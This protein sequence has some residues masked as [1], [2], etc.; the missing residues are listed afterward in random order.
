LLKLKAVCFRSLHKEGAYLFIG[1]YGGGYYVMKSKKLRAMPLDINQHLKYAH[2][3]MMDDAGYCWI[4]TNSGLFKARLSDITTAFDKDQQHIYY[5]YLGKDD[6]MEITE[7][8]G[9][10]TP[11]AIRLKNRNFSFPTMDGLVWFNPEKMNIAL[12]GGEIYLDKLIVDDK[13]IHETGRAV[14]QLPAQVSRIEATFVTSA[15]C[16]KENLH[17]TYQLDKGP[18]LPVDMT[19]GEPR[20]SFH[21]LDD[22][23]HV[24]SIRKVTGFG[25]NNYSSIQT[26][27]NIATPYYD[28]WWFRT[29]AVMAFA[30]LVY[31]IV[32]LRLRQ[33]HAREKKL[34][35]LVAQKTM[36]LNV[37]NAE[38]EKNDEIKSRLIAVINHDII[39]PL[40]FMHYAGNA[41]VE[42]KHNLSP[43]EQLKTIAEITQTAKQMEVLSSQIL[44]WIIYQNPNKTMQ[45]EEFDLHQLVE[46]VFR[47]LQFP[48][49][50]KNVTLKN[51]VPA[52]FVIYQYLEPVRVMIYN[53]LLNGLNFTREGSVR[54][55]CHKDKDRV[56]IQ[57]TDDGWGMTREQIDNLMSDEKIITSANVDN[58]KGTGLGYMIIKD[59]LKMMDGT[60]FIRSSKGNGT[61]VSVS[62]PVK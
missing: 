41:L 10:C 25:E 21:N 35:A 13:T 32:R 31:L 58:K 34:S 38:L 57:V 24:L 12:P 30:A 50:Q 7:M 18:W 6:G 22:G 45:K 11:C 55:H 19:S 17:I 27:F 46:M 1:T 16:K 52:N 28:Q 48:A 42:N 56:I 15:W 59:L 53:F 5:Y 44:N 8:N 54:V 20:I 3:F 61:E 2:C 14:I 29:L 60:L 51:D 4:S 9:G 47:V 23:R 26:T 39:T 33:Y 62:L 36:D 40:H 37:K 49:R 43:E